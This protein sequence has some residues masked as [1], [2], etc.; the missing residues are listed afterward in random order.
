MKEAYKG[1]FEDVMKQIEEDMETSTYYY[2]DCVSKLCS[3][4][5][6]KIEGKAP[7]EFYGVGLC[8]TAK[9][10]DIERR[11]REWVLNKE[12]PEETRKDAFGNEIKVG[13]KVWCIASRDELKSIGIILDESV[14]ELRSGALIIESLEEDKEE[15]TYA[16]FSNTGWFLKTESLS[17]DE[18]PKDHDGQHIYNGDTVYLRPGDWCCK[19]PLFGAESGCKLEVGDLKPFHD[20]DGVIECHSEKTICYP[21]PDQVTHEEPKKTC[22]ECKFYLVDCDTGFSGPCIKK[23][24]WKGDDLYYKQVNEKDVACNRFK[25]SEK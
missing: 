25:P 5:P 21:K 8:A 16:R 11:L 17:V 18:P 7:S 14:K 10:R 2:F 23:Y 13:D 3:V 15:G 22:G 1:S 6:A 4:C 19:Y 12:K 24:G 9:K 20:L